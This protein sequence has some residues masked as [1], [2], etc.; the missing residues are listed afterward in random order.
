MSNID[1]IVDE[2]EKELIS[3]FVNDLNKDWRGM[4]WEEMLDYIEE[5]KEKWE[6]KI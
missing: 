4:T 2:A 1:F 6:E 3:E 5:L